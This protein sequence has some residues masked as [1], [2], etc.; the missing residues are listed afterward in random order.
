M[1]IIDALE[2]K[3]AVHL[4]TIDCASS[5]DNIDRAYQKTCADIMHS[6]TNYGDQLPNAAR[7]IAQAALGCEVSLGDSCNSD[8]IGLSGT[9]LFFARSQDQPVA[10][11]KA[12]ASTTSDFLQ[13]LWAQQNIFRVMPYV[14]RAIHA[15]KAQVSQQDY[16]LLV[17]Q[18]IPGTVVNDLILALAAMPLGAERMAATKPVEHITYKI[19]E[20]LARLHTAGPA[21]YGASS[22]SMSEMHKRAL[23]RSIA[24]F[25][26]APAFG[27]DPDQLKVNV[28]SLM[29]TM[30]AHQF[31]YAYLHG[32]AHPG[33][34]L[35]NETCDKISAL[36][37]GNGARSI[38]GQRKPAGSPLTDYVRF[39]ASMKVREIFG[40]TE[41]ETAMFRAAF[42][43]GYSAQGGAVPA[44]EV[45]QCYIVMEVMDYAAWYFDH[46]DNL[47]VPVRSVMES[48]LRTGLSWL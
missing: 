15:G 16:L 45:E 40:I 46:A 2:Q 4:A 17:S 23:N 10:V 29:Q 30:S 31:R 7:A 33:N 8:L 39:T 36:D 37:L 12:F 22:L 11:I 41:A 21:H 5:A 43:R 48:I 35:Y 24:G 28:Q 3:I 13:V 32:D 42:D 27:V 1:N 26:L 19:G 34:F 25:K 38:T 9:P 14:P 44:R 20:L 6:L 18:F 47:S